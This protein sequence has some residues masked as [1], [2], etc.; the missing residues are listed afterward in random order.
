[1]T[2]IKPGPSCLGSC[3]HLLVGVGSVKAQDEVGVP[4]VQKEICCPKGDREALDALAEVSGDPEV[5]DKGIHKDI[6]GRE[7]QRRKK[8]RAGLKVPM[9]AT[10]PG[11]HLRGRTLEERILFP[12]FYHTLLLLEVPEAN[13][14][15]VQSGVFWHD[16]A[17]WV[18]VS[19]PQC[20]Q[21]SFGHGNIHGDGE[22]QS[23][24]GSN[25]RR[26][27]SARREV[28]LV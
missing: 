13:N 6:L 4:A 19:M 22:L 25:H 27:D 14:C 28:A 15:C 17:M 7:G 26:R 24:D 20:S 3:A 2:G 10:S 11:E 12:H 16:S 8:I 21:P 9:T 1:M 18:S 23:Q 5:R